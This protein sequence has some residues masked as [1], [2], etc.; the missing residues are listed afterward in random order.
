MNICLKL[1]CAMFAMLAL[2]GCGGGDTGGGAP[3]SYVFPAGTATL[4]FT[5]MST[6]HLTAPISGIDLSLTLPQGMSVTTT[7]GVSGQISTAS[8]MPG[9]SLVGTNLAFG[10]YSASSGTV[11]LSTVTTSDTFRS[12]EFLRLSCT[13]APNTNIT[14]GSLKALNS[15]L[16]ALKAVGYDPAT[17][18][19]VDLS[20][21]LKVTL[22][23]VN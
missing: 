20:A 3:D 14:L 17:M 18:S 6:A 10:T 13:V 19:T 1:I 2:F 11:R 23:A 4:T 21:R 15:P 16:P 9:S 22:G 7:G 8:L 5:A 12:G